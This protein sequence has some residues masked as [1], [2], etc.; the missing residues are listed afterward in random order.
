MSFRRFL[1]FAIAIL[2]VAAGI[3]SL[4]P[5]KPLPAAF[6]RLVQQ[7]VNPFTVPEDS[8]SVVKQRIIRFLNEPRHLLSRDRIQASD[9]VWQIPYYNSYAKGDRILIEMH[10]RGDSCRFFCF[11][12]YSRQ[13]DEDGSKEMALYKQKGISRYDFE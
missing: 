8:M 11:R 2:L 12:W 5:D 1:F 10:R 4:L 6:T 13:A 7:Q 9:S 3:Y